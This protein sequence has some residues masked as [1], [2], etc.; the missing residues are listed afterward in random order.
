MRALVAIGVWLG[1]SVGALAQSPMVKL[2]T[3]AQQKA[4]RAWFQAVR[5]H[6]AL[7]DIGHSEKYYDPA[8]VGFTVD[9]SGK[10]VSI[11]MVKR[12]GSLEH[13]ARLERGMLGAGPYPPPPPEI[14]GATVTSSV[15]WTTSYMP[16]Y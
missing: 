1:L 2:T 5:D 15:K 4:Y 3:P 10:L 16:I 12:S 8:V 13:D 11:W 6:L 14:P 7:Y 9:R